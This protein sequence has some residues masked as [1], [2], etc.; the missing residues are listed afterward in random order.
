[1]MEEEI[2]RLKEKK[3]GIVKKLNEVLEYEQREELLEELKRLEKQI[4]VLK[5][6]R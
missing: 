3:L 2:E 4:E 6:L 5:K 1:M